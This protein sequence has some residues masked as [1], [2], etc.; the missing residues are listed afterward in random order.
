MWRSPPFK[1]IIPRHYSSQCTVRGD[2]GGLGSVCFPAIRLQPPLPLRQGGGHR[3]S[4][5]KLRARSHTII[6]LSRLFHIIFFFLRVFRRTF[7]DRAR[8]EVVGGWYFYSP[9]L[10][11]DNNSFQAARIRLYLR[12][13]REREGAATAVCPEKCDMHLPLLE[14]S[15]FLFLGFY[16]SFRPPSTAFNSDFAERRWGWGGWGKSW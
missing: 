15:R 1:R 14:A 4:S 10:A 9:H 12:K 8:G 2:G 13:E 7:K 3:K 5:P 16:K 6:S 11:L